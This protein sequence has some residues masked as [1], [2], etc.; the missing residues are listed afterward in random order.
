[1]SSLVAL[2]D[3]FTCGEGV[4]VHVPSLH[5]WPA[6]LAH[7]GGLTPMSL[8]AAGARVRDVR[9]L[10]LPNAP[11]ARVA[12]VLVGLN[13]IC[14]G[15]FH[16]EQFH[17]DLKAVVDGMLH[18]SRVVLLGRLH[19]PSQFLRLPRRLRRIVH[20]RVRAVNVAVDAAADSSSR[21][22]VLDLARVPALGWRCAWAADG[23]HPNAYGHAALARAAGGVLDAA[24]QRFVSPQLPPAQPATTA[25]QHARWLVRH[26]APYIVS[27]S[28]VFARPVAEALRRA[29]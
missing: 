19:D 8:A 11:Q 16:A 9:E 17:D 3:S 26:G 18:R 7:H 10:Q 29:G 27:H 22:A 1:M 20:A 25:L 12:T 6:V 4:G 21:V 2:G 28:R 23:V 13:D 15:S 5:T 24:G 14:R